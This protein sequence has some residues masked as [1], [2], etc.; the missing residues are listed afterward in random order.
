MWKKV[1]V[2]HVPWVRVIDF[3][4]RKENKRD[5]QCKFI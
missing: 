1:Y 5:V 3:L 4:V 2:A